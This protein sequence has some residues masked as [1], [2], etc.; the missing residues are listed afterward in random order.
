MVTFRQFWPSY[1]TDGY[2]QTYF[3]MLYNWRLY[4]YHTES[5]PG[6]ESIDDCGLRFL[7]AMRHHIYLIRTLPPIQRVQIRKQGLKSSSLVW[8]YH[9]E[10]TEVWSVLPYLVMNSIHFCLIC[11]PSVVL[12]IIVYSLYDFLCTILVLD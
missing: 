4:F 9:S 12:L 2:V 1:I 3:T 11:T 5:Q 7:L 10:S 8:A 6:A